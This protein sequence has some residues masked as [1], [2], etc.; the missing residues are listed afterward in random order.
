MTAAGEQPVVNIWR[1]N[2]RWRHS[3]ARLL[4]PNDR[5]FLE[6]LVEQA[7]L[8]EQATE[9]LSRLRPGHTVTRMMVDELDGLE[10]GAD[11]VRR[12]LID[13]L[14]ST[15]TTPFDREDIFALSRAIDDVVDAAN[16]TVVELS[17][18]KMAVPDKLDTMVASLRQGAHHLRLAISELLDHPRLAAEHAVRAK[19]AENRV[20][21]A[22]H[23]A[24]AKLLDQDLSPD[25]LKARE[26][27]RHLKSSADRIDRA[28]D[29]VAMIVIKSL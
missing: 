22:Y 7:D 20:D 24:I 4:R 18:Y 17:I 25:V 2:L 21:Q 1:A 14:L 26:I 27:Y 12:A 29:Q 15:F 3:I 9:A 6:L 28:A 23:E 11:Q 19:R 10:K 16:E 13:E 8:C 5:R